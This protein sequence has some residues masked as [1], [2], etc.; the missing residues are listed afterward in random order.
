LNSKP[1]RGPVG[2]VTFAAASYVLWLITA[3]VGILTLLVARRLLLEI[4]YALNVNPWAHG[5]IDK[6]GLL[7][8]AVVWIVL[9]YGTEAYY[10]K[11][12]SV[13]LRELLRRFVILTGT[14]VVFVGLALLAITLMV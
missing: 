4:A 12:A 1:D 2:Q 8:F 10:R 5:A 9:T 14:Q 3:A 7:I 13:S 6:F 11:A